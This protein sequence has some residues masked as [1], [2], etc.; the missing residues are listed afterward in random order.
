MLAAQRSRQP[1]RARDVGALPPAAT[2]RRAADRAAGAIA[3]F[4]KW[5]PWVFERLDGFRLG[6]SAERLR[7]GTLTLD[8]PVPV[9][10][11]DH[12]RYQGWRAGHASLL[13][14]LSERGRAA[15]GT[16]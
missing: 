1:A 9:F 13:V 10:M 15:S 2:R 4:G 11:L 3:T 7:Y 14:L 6:G 5:M 8:S 12:P 16:T